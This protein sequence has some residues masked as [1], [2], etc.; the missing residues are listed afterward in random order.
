MHGMIGVSVL[1]EP[2]AFR[3]PGDGNPVA[4]ARSNDLQ[5]STGASVPNPHGSIANRAAACEEFVVGTPVR[6]RNLSTRMPVQNEGCA[7]NCRLLDLHR[8]IAPT[9]YRS[10][11]AIPA[12]SDTHPRSAVGF[13]VNYTA[14]AIAPR[15]P[16]LHRFLGDQGELAVGGAPAYLVGR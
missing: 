5:L 15:V 2:A 11:L 8:T 13:K 9:V 6:G 7:L 14:R 10:A 3:G 12:P 16:E 1:G 4:S